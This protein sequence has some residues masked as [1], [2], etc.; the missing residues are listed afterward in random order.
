MPPTPQLKYY[1]RFRMECQLGQSQPLPVL[2]SGFEFVPW[3]NYLSDI[4]ADIKFRCFVDDLDARVFPNLGCVKGCRELMNA[5]RTRVGF[6]PQATWL[7]AGPDGFAGTVQGIRNAENWG[8]IQN[9]GIVPEYRGIGLGEAL[10]LQAMQ[11]F[12]SA[13]ALGIY[14]EVTAE[15]TAAVRLYRK[16]G[17]RCTR[18]V[19]K[20]VLADSTSTAGAGI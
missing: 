8:A 16:L 10:M 19:Y 7:I 5:I 3:V 14:L 13:G 12:Q 2:P 9:L 18:T 6:C 17:F 1:K 4:H 11:G 15:N 20:A